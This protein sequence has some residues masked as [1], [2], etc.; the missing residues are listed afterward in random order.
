MSAFCSRFSFVLKPRLYMP[1]WSHTACNF[2]WW[3]TFPQNGRK[4]EF[5]KWILLVLL[6]ADPETKLRVQKVYQ[7][8]TSLKI[9]EGGSRIERTGKAFRLKCRSHKVWADWTGSSKARINTGV[10]RRA[11]MAKAGTPIMVIHWQ[12][13]LGWMRPWLYRWSK[14]CRRLS[15]YSTP[16]RSTARIFLK[17]IPSGRPFWLP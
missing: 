17:G 11:E 2:L 15:A 12:G 6:E 16:C 7:V 8:L 5:R 3:S 9:K 14:S 4:K 13:L 10:L 1:A